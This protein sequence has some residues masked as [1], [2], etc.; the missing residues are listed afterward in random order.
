MTEINIEPKPRQNALPYVIGLLLVAVIAF[1]VWF[2]MERRAP[3]ANDAFDPA[4]PP[5]AVD[6]GSGL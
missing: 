4:A 2:F 6:T 3:A 1:A 5:A